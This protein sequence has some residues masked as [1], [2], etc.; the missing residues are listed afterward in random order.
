[1]VAIEMFGSTQR[2]TSVL[3][4]TKFSFGGRRTYSTVRSNRHKPPRNLGRS[5]SP[6]P[7][8]PTDENTMATLVRMAGARWK[9]DRDTTGV[10][11][12]GKREFRWL[13]R[14]LLEFHAI[15]SSRPGRVNAVVYVGTSV[16]AVAA[17]VS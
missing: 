12:A 7:A 14:Q 10:L 15:R 1:M 16:I 5:I 3:E 11:E 8:I 6:A 13:N 17:F 4:R 2:V 9:A